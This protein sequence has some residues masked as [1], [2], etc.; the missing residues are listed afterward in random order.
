[1]KTFLRTT[2]FMILLI[3]SLNASVLVRYVPEDDKTIQPSAGEDIFKKLRGSTEF[4]GKLKTPFSA[5]KK[6]SRGGE[7]GP[8]ASSVNSDQDAW[9]RARLFLRHIY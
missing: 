4:F 8:P 3:Q 7:L 2:F 5:Q 6:F 1:M 9:K